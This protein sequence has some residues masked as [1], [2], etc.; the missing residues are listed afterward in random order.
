MLLKKKKRISKIFKKVERE[1]KVN[2]E[3]L[4]D[5]SFEILIKAKSTLESVGEG[6]TTVLG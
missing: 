1:M 5:F 2:K 6:W 4:S 3:F